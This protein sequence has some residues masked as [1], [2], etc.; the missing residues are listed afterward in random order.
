MSL[1]FYEGMRTTQRMNTAAASW[2]RPPDRIRSNAGARA[3]QDEWRTKKARVVILISIFL[4]FI[5][6]A[7]LISCRAFIG[8]MIRAAAEARQMNRVGEVVFTLPDGAFCRRLAFDN[9]TAEVSEST[10]DRCPEAR[11]R[12]R[13]KEVDTSTKGFAWGSDN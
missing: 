13:K 2:Y 1:L 12:G 11:P 4:V 9:K 3:R 5:A 7:V 6:A 8:S 10:V